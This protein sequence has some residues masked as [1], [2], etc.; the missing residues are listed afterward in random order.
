MPQRP[1][2]LPQP[3]DSAAN[4]TITK[5]LISR[6]AV[7]PALSERD[8][9]REREREG[10]RGRERKRNHI[11]ETKTENGNGILRHIPNWEP[12]LASLWLVRADFSPAT[13]PPLMHVTH[14]CMNMWSLWKTGDGE[15]SWQLSVPTDPEWKQSAVVCQQ[16]AQTL[17]LTSEHVHLGPSSATQNQL[18]PFS[19]WFCLP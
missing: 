7:S 11:N 13:A 5:S 14:P 18:M 2:L 4:C 12:K 16:S 1:P 10:E 9:E 17:P 19:S 8:W 6:V 3:H 15:G